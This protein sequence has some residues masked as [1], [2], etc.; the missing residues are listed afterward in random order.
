MTHP[1]NTGP[2]G[3]LAAQF[4][5]EFLLLDDLVRAGSNPEIARLE[6]DLADAEFERKEAEAERD[7]AVQESR[8]LRRMAAEANTRELCL[9]DTIAQLRTRNAALVRA[10]GLLVGAVV[11]GNPLPLAEALPALESAGIEVPGFW[12]A[13]AVPALSP[14]QRLAVAA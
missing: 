12:R 5:R 13:A 2:T 6:S 1:T 3:R 14:S 10:L 7:A 11:D 8:E 4:D 9:G